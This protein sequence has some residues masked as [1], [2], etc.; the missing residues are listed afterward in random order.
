MLQCSGNDAPFFHFILIIAK[1]RICLSS[2]CLTVGKNCPVYAF[3]DTLLIKEQKYFND[4]FCNYIVK[5]DL[6]AFGVEDGVK[7]ENLSFVVPFDL[8]LKKAPLLDI[9]PLSVSKISMY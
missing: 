6:V 4:W 7:V 9:I 1:H 5:A 3:Q 2:A 8:K